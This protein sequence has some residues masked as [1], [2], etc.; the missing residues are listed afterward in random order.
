MNRTTEQTEPR[1]ELIAAF[2]GFLIAVYLLLFL[3][4]QLI[5]RVPFQSRSIVQPGEP[6]PQ[7]L[8][9]DRSIEKPRTLS[10]KGPRIEDLRPMLEA[11]PDP[12][13]VIPAKPQIE[14]IPQEQPR[15]ELQPENKI[16]SSTISD[17]RSRNLILPLKDLKA[18]DL[19]DSFFESRGGSRRHEA[20]DI[21]APRNTPILAVEDGKIAR[22]WYSEFGGITIYQIDPSETYVYYYAHL[23]RYA[24]DLD[25]GD[26]VKKGQTIGYV[27]TSG[28]APPNTP[29]L[30]FTIF[31]LTEQKHWWEGT[32]INPFLVYR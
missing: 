17:L 14:A 2:L 11:P 21:L 28:N 22:L 19:R 5:E 15:L 4:N 16:D 23:Q 20:I 25:E 3:Y 30:H 8:P 1:Y 13:E 32:A 6:V 9:I 7:P 10:D 12:P 27:G 18:D 31:K 24:D 26:E 29:H